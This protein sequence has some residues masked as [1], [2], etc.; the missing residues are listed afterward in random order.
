M[1]PPNSVE[2][3]CE[4]LKKEPI[5]IAVFGEFS[6]GKSTF[7]NALIGE[8]ILSIAVEPTTAVPTFIRYGRAF[9]ISV[10]KKFGNRL[11]VLKLFEDTPPPWACFVGRESILNTLNSQRNFIRSFLSEWTSEKKR[12]AE[13]DQVAIEL[14]LPWLKNGIELIDTP[15]TNVEFAKHRDITSRIAIEADIAILLMDARQ[16]GGK[17]TEF[18]FMNEVNSRVEEA[19]V[20]LN[21]ID[22]LDRDERE[23]IVEYV[24]EEALIKHWSGTIMP[25]VVAASSV[26]RLDSTVRERE[27]ELHEDFLKLIARLE[28]TAIKSRGAMLLNRL[29]NPEKRLFAEAHRHETEGDIESAYHIYY[30]LSDILASGGMDPSPAQ[31]GIQ[32]TDKILREKVRKLNNAEGIIKNALDLEKNEP[33]KAFEQL[34][35]LLEEDLNDPVMENR[36][37]EIV[38]RLKERIDKRNSTRREINKRMEIANDFIERDKYFPFYKFPKFEP[39]LLQK[40]EFSETEINT[41]RGLEKNCQKRKE[42]FNS[43]YTHIEKEA[44]DLAEN[45]KP[46]DALV[47]LKKLINKVG[48]YTGESPSELTEKVK[49]LKLRVEKLQDA[50]KHINAFLTA[51]ESS[52]I[53]MRG[54]LADRVAEILKTFDEFEQNERQSLNDKVQE[55]LRLRDKYISTALVNFRKEAVLFADR[56]QYDELRG[57]IEALNPMIEYSKEALDFSNELHKRNEAWKSYQKDLVP[58]INEVAALVE[59]I[60]APRKQGI[61]L[62]QRI[63]SCAENF[64]ILF[65]KAPQTTT[66]SLPEKEQVLTINEK[67]ELFNATKALVHP[68]IKDDIE[69]D[70]TFS[71]SDKKKILLNRLSEIERINVPDR[72]KLIEKMEEYPDHPEIN[73]YKE[74]LLNLSPF[75]VTKIKA[76]RIINQINI[77]NIPDVNIKRFIEENFNIISGGVGIIIIFLLFLF[78]SGGLFGWNNILNI[79]TDY[80]GIVTLISLVIIFYFLDTIYYFFPKLALSFIILTIISLTILFSHYS[81][82]SLIFSFKISFFDRVIGSISLPISYTIFSIALNNIL[83]SFTWIQIKIID[84]II[85][86]YPKC[87]EAYVNRGMIYFNSGKFQDAI[88]DF[89]KAI[90]LDPKNADFYCARGGA[91]NHLGKYNDAI[92]DFDRAIKLDPQNAVGYHLRGLAYDDI[93]EYDNAFCDYNKVIELDPQNA[94]IYVLRGNISCQQYNNYSKGAADYNKYLKIQGNRDGEAEGIR[95]AIRSLGYKPKY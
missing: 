39:D 87:A 45:Y 16:G 75:F 46:E 54:K 78:F 93:R 13:V 36:I 94:I 25:P 71:M 58:V 10:Y 56:K 44:D 61:K 38:G 31:E 14:P 3:I 15:G 29:D 11:Q 64:T 7:L 18:E 47:A 67:L 32:R 69:R 92:L 76:K 28:D 68:S 65:G 55:V 9:N 35:I 66:P 84:E 12:A 57:L 24:Q 63:T 27:P 77:L 79:C 85:D 70:C 53:L 86:V 41:I 50:R 4:F 89:S 73:K 59:K 74:K 82:L 51:D 42:E 33:D 80:V 52:P 23:D 72:P 62:G 26:V 95:Q 21:K 90:D 34:T 60:D 43:E 2:D 8:D 17:R 81:N 37:L 40:A 88:T 19:F 83:E 48:E 20:V 1:P 5:R 49:L 30:D 22:L 6:C 91:Y